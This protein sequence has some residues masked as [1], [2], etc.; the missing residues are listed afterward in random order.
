MLLLPVWMIRHM[1]E[2]MTVTA[3]NRPNSIVYMTLE[4]KAV[5]AMKRREK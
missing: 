1:I 5:N 2:K 3:A 4:K